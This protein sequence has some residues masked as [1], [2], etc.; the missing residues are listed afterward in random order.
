MYN[1]HG[2]MCPGCQGEGSVGGWNL[3]KNHDPNDLKASIHGHFVK[4]KYLNIMF[5]MSPQMLTEQ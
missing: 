3:R 2:N 4:S 1:C 5:I